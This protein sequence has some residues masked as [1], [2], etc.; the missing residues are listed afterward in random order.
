MTHLEMDDGK[1]DFRMMSRRMVEA[2][3]DMKEYHRYMKGLYS[4]VGF[5]TKWIEYENIQRENGVTKWS[6][7]NLF[8]YAMEGILSFSTAPLKAAGV[9]G[10][11]V[12]IGG[13]ICMLSR[14]SVILCA[15]M[16]FSGMQMI[17]LYIIGVY[18]SKD[19]LE[20]KKRPMYIIKERG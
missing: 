19:Y 2:I 17:F 1:G 5:E 6:L 9:F 16:L 7:K 4:F 20:N 11:I 10:L 3:L 15:V 12:L 14:Q 18:L 13:V 8:V